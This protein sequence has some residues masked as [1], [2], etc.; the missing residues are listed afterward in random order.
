MASMADAA[1]NVNVNKLVPNYADPYFDW[2]IIA[3][4]N[5]YKFT[6]RNAPKTIK[7]IHQNMKEESS[8]MELLRKFSLIIN[9]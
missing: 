1:E 8:K 2:P 3:S 9:I 6:L 7:R 4:V 5:T